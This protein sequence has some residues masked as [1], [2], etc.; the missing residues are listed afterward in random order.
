MSAQNPVKVSNDYFPDFPQPLLSFVLACSLACMSFS[1]YEVVR[2]AFQWR[3][4]FVNSK[5]VF[6]KIFSR[7]AGA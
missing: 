4:W 5:S 7:L 3:I 1:V 2:L 6:Y